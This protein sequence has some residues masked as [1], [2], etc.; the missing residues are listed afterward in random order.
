MATHLINTKKLLKETVIELCKHDRLAVDT[1]TYGPD[2]VGGLHPFHGSRSFSIIFATKDDEY[3][4]SFN[5]GDINP[6]FKK[7]LQPIF[8]DPKRIM[9]FVNAIF[10][11]TIMHFDNLKVKNRI[12]DA[13]SIARIEYNKHGKHA[14]AK[15]TFLSMEYLA[16]YYDVQLK[17]DLVKKYIKDNNLY[18]TKRCRFT[19]KVIPLYNLVPL[20]LMVEYAGSDART[21]FDLCT[22]IIKN[23]NYKDEKYEEERRGVPPMIE[24]AKNE[25]ATTP[26]L[27]DMK[28]SGIK[29]WDKYIK[30]AIVHETKESIKLHKV[31]DKLTNGIN[32]NSGKQIGEYLVGRGVKVPRNEVTPH[33]LKMRTNWKEKAE[34]ARQKGNEKALR[35]CLEKANNY[36]LGNYCTDK[37]TLKKLM[38][39]YPKLD[40]LSKITQAKEADKKIG[41]YYKNYQLLKDHNDIMHCGLNQEVPKTGRLSSNSPNLQNIEKKYIKPSSGEYSVRNSFIADEGH[42]LFFADYSQQE[43]IVMLD[44]AGEMSVI[45]KLLSG[46]FEDFYLATSAVLKESLGVEITRAQAKAMALGLAYGKGINALAKELGLTVEKAKQFRDEFFRGLP[47]LKKLM[48]KLQN[49][50]KWYGKIHNAFGRVLYFDDNEAYRSLNGFVQGTSADITKTAMVNVVKYLKEAGLKS[51]LTLSVHDELIFNIKIGEED[52][53]L[54]LIRKAMVEAYPH[55]HIP[56]QVDFE[57]SEINNEGVSPWGEKQPYLL[58]S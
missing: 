30:R 12:I 54:P 40:F 33:A 35:L 14:W 36:L 42:R 19:G 53:A 25:I 20:D 26:V 21:T 28:I 34:Q 45:N 2:D 3:Y 29:A 50:V 46:E 39:K 5:T 7:D 17:S 31:V 47:K 32:L 43:M 44:Q 23:I 37:K 16:E 9:F 55:I 8:D 38:V 58:V 48:N 24:V 1:E 57:Y 10:D 6:K 51:R 4:F 15:E 22:T 52:K 11:C 27:I 13:P 18:S 41:T 56:L 49:Q